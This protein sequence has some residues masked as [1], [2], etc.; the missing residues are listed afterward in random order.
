MSE[1]LYHEEH[2]LDALREME[3]HAAAASVPGN[4]SGTEDRHQREL[5]AKWKGNK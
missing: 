3:E 4:G 1:E 5:E 2:P